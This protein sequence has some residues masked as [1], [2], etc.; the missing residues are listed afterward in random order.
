MG[1]TNWLKRNQ[2]KWWG[3]RWGRARGQDKAAIWPITF[4]RGSLLWGVIFFVAD[5]RIL[6]FWFSS[7]SPS[8]N[9]S[10]LFP[11]PHSASP[12]LYADTCLLDVLFSG[13]NYMSAPWLTCGWQLPPV[14][15]IFRWSSSWV[16]ELF[17]IHE[18]RRICYIVHLF[19]GTKKA[20]NKQKGILL[21]AVQAHL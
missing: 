12:Q 7:C 15:F 16:W 8:L 5:T 11:N 9:L 19:T 1:T 3:W 18:E 17:L 4:C 2:T 6:D 13:L 10:T 21:G 14:H 20:K